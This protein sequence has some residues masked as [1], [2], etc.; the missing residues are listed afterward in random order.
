[1]KNY[2]IENYSIENYSIFLYRANSI[3]EKFNIS[4]MKS[5]REGN[6]NKECSAY[7]VQDIK[8]DKHQNVSFYRFMSPSNSIEL[9]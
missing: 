1:M 2:S 7:H 4:Q 5:G 8:Y 3:T 9:V 6:A